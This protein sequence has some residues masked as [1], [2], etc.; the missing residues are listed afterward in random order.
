MIDFKKKTVLKFINQNCQQTRYNSKRIK[1]Q[2]NPQGWYIFCLRPIWPFYQKVFGRSFAK[3][4]LENAW[5]RPG[6]MP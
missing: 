6:S 4:N 5:N 1:I 3:E 2:I